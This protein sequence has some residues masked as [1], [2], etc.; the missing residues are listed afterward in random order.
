LPV[1]EAHRGFFRLDGWKVHFFVD[2]TDWFSY[3][4]MQARLGQTV[5]GGSDGQE[6]KI[7][8]SR[9]ARNSE[10]SEVACRTSRS[11]CG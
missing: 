5:E 2:F 6:G 7:E 1:L 8:E 11:S 9:K 3:K 10:G 4:V